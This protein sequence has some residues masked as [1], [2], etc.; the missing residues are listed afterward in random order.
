V[1][2]VTTQ[3]AC[4]SQIHPHP[5]TFFSVLVKLHLTAEDG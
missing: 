3:S 1:Q 5:N 2:S 4:L